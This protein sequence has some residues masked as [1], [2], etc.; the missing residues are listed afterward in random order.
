MFKHY[1]Q[2]LAL[3]NFDTVEQLKDACR[4]IENADTIVRNRPNSSQQAKNFIPNQ[5]NFRPVNNNAPLNYQNHLPL[6]QQHYNSNNNPNF[7]SRPQIHWNRSN[8]KNNRQKFNRQI[9]NQPQNQYSRNQYPQN[10]QQLLCDMY[11]ETHSVC[12]GMMNLTD[13]INKSESITRNLIAI[14]TKAAS[15]ITTD[16]KSCLTQITDIARVSNII[17]DQMKEVYMQYI[18]FI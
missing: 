1:V 4:Q 14:N 17:K 12:K 11:T 8:N 6:Q 16:M 2:T 5:S 15:S 10:H 9:Q 13:H 7:S 18:L 3:Y